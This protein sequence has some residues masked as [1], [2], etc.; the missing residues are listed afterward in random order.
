VVQA[1][2]HFQSS[3]FLY[4]SL[5]ETL[6]PGSVFKGTAEAKKKVILMTDIFSR[7]AGDISPNFFIGQNEQPGDLGHHTQASIVG[8][9]DGREFSF[10]SVF[11]SFPP[12]INPPNF[13]NDKD[14]LVSPLTFNID[15][16]GYFLRYT[17][18]KL[19][20]LKQNKQ[21]K[22]VRTPIKG[23]SGSNALPISFEQTVFPDFGFMPMTRDFIP[24][25][26]TLHPNPPI[27]SDPT[28]W[29]Y[30]Y[31]DA[32]ILHATDPICPTQI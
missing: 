9:L 7:S 10:I 5:N 22:P 30:L 29:T 27:P 6:Y 8:C 12:N 28:T 14:E 2:Q 20:M 1:A 21:V 24:G 26:K 23:L 4:V 18:Q 32:A 31:L 15:W 25:W 13:V 16:G 19:S 17:D 3:Q 11:N